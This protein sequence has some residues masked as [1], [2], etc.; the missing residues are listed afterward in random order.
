MWLYFRVAFSWTL[1]CAGQGHPQIVRCSDSKYGLGLL[2]VKCAHKHRD[3]TPIDACAD[4]AFFC[5]LDDSGLPSLK[6]NHH[7][8]SQVQGQLGICGAR[9]CDFVVYTNKKLTIERIPIDLGYLLWWLIKFTN[10]TPNMWSLFCVKMNQMMNKQPI[11]DFRSL[12][13]SRLLLNESSLQI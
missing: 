2:E 8:F 5:A 3:V 12:F 7:Y 11:T 9:W 1:K 10:S 13:F 6:R 4:P